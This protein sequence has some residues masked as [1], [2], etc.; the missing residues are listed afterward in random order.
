M[1]SFFHSIGVLV[2]DAP[3][4]AGVNATAFGGQLPDLDS[5]VLVARAFVQDAAPWITWSANAGFG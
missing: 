5:G 4:A 2:E 1:G 3:H